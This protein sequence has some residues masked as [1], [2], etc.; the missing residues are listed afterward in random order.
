MAHE[1]TVACG[2]SSALSAQTTARLNRS[3]S[4][5]LGTTLNRLLCVVFGHAPVDEGPIRHCRR[6]AQVRKLT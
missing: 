2:I 5:R 1:T 4:R 6:C 3:W